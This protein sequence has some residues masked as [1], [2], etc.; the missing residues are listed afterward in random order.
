MSYNDKVIMSLKITSTI[1]QQNNGKHQVPI[2]AF[3]C[4]Q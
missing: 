3:A 4:C 2:D 1:Q